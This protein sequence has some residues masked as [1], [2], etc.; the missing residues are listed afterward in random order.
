[1]PKLQCAFKE[2]LPNQKGS[3]IFPAVAFLAAHG[4]DFAKRD[5]AFFGQLAF[6][7]S[8]AIGYAA[9]TLWVRVHAKPQCDNL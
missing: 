2:L 3:D 6:F 9:V 8:I 1:V 4:P 7:D 5:I